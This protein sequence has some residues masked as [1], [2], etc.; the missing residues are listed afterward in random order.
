MA[1]AC[2]AIPI[3]QPT[4]LEIA[5]AVFIVIAIIISLLLWWCGGPAVI[6]RP[7]VY[8]NFLLHP[9]IKRRL[10]APRS[11]F[12]DLPARNIRTITSDGAKLYGWHILPAGAESTAAAA[13]FTPCAQPEQ[14][15]QQ[16][17]FDF[18]NEVDELVFDKSLRKA[19][20]VVLY[21]HGIAG[22]RGGVW[23]S[24]QSARVQLMR[25][26][27]AHFG[28][29]VICFDY[30]GFGDCCD[31]IA[32]APPDGQFWARAKTRAP[33]PSEEGLLLDSQA[34]WR[35][36]EARVDPAR[37]SVFVYGQSMGTAVAVGLLSELALV[38]TKAMEQQR[39]EEL[40]RGHRRKS[41]EPSAVSS[42]TPEKSLSR[43]T[44]SPMRHARVIEMSSRLPLRPAGL[45]LDAPFTNLRAAAAHHPLSRWCPGPILDFCLRQLGD[46]W[47]TDERLPG[48]LRCSV[49]FAASATT[50]SAPASDAST[51]TLPASASLTQ[52]PL[53]SS[54]GRL[55]PLLVIHKIHDEVVPYE[56]GREV[57]L[58]A[59][60]AS[61]DQE[62]LNRWVFQ[63]Q[64]LSPILSSSSSSSSIR[65]ALKK[66]R[67]VTYPPP[68]LKFATIS[69]P[70]VMKRH[71]IDAFATS[72]WLH[73]MADFFG[74]ARAEYLQHLEERATLSP[75]AATAA[76]SAS[77][78]WSTTNSINT[79][80]HQQPQ[81]DEGSISSSNGK[82]GKTAGKLISDDVKYM[83]LG[84][85]ALKQRLVEME[86]HI[87]AANSPAKAIFTATSSGQSSITNAAVLLAS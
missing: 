75:M 30:R 68:T 67:A 8:L 83:P 29:H 25:A 87:A 6:V 45:V 10:K 7:L 15:E 11:F 57:F 74:A 86:E 26:L 32:V 55:L 64:S 48:A 81:D 4:L 58:K 2:A 56:L 20:R 49:S 51:T 84:S 5:I 19:K 31:D 34:A 40:K 22:S 27:A 16:T 76:R 42:S 39:V 33:V 35:W 14:S 50:T 61:E 82:D 44:P 17:E 69:R 79:T 71:H 80:L 3:G 21:F 9:G 12:F 41:S 53:R 77:R 72:D 18:W 28:A 37:C 1:V 59:R 13:S 43:A 36:L 47:C 65:E 23:V 73:S 78:L 52:D 62:A 60:D 54:T 85:G 66:Q 38:D 63:R 46:S 24:S 70:K